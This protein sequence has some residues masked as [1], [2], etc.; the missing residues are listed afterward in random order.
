MCSCNQPADG[1][2]YGGQSDSIRVHIFVTNTDE[3]KR[4]QE[5]F[6]LIND[7]C[8]QPYFAEIVK[9]VNTDT[10]ETTEPGTA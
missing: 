2:A 4:A 10:T 8:D 7:L 9:L 3:K 1:D 6:R 5:L